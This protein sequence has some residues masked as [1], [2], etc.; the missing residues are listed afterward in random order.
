MSS[1][2]RFGFYEKV[3]VRSRG[4]THGPVGDEVGA[5]LG[6][7][8]GDDGCWSYAVYIYRLETCWSLDEGE[9]EPT[10]EFD[11]RE[12]FYDGSSIRVQVDE[13]GRGLLAGE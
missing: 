12:T 6:K 7:A 5:V 2:S 3:R 4:S 9:L 13:A 1:T 10:G 8:Q 11:S